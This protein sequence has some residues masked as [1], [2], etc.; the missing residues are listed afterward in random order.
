MSINRWFLG[1]ALRIACERQVGQSGGRMQVIAHLAARAGHDR[2]LRV[3]GLAGETISGR[4]LAAGGEA[5]PP[6]ALT[7]SEAAAGRA[8]YVVYLRRHEFHEHDSA[9][10]V[11]RVWLRWYW[12]A[13][14]LDDFTSRGFRRANVMRVARMEV[15]K[16][17]AALSAELQQPVAPSALLALADGPQLPHDATL[18]ERQGFVDRVLSTLVTAGLVQARGEGFEIAPRAAV[19]LEA[20]D[21]DLQRYSQ[22]AA[23]RRAIHALILATGIAALEVGGTV[24]PAPAPDEADLSA[25]TCRSGCGACDPDFSGGPAELAPAAA[26]DTAARRPGVSTGGAGFAG[27]RASR[28]GAAAHASAPIRALTARRLAAAGQGQA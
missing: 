12:L 6:V 19:A 8:R 4:G 3:T 20:Y 11:L 22:L 23:M 26:L 14:W 7:L 1:R 15:A 18:E 28:T 13:A 24:A 16:R 5:P 2:R 27:A 21:A 17:V 9:R 25:A 10:L